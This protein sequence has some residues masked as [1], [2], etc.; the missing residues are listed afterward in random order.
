M[1][2][3]FCF[4]APLCLHSAP[5]PP[6]VQGLILN[7]D[8]NEMSSLSRAVRSGDWLTTS[9]SEGVGPGT[10]SATVEQE[11]P[12]HGNAPFGSSLPRIT[13]EKPQWVTPGPNSYTPQVERGHR[14]AHIDTSGPRLHIE[15]VLSKHFTPG[16][17]AYTEFVPQKPPDQK[18]ISRVNW[19]KKVSPPSIPSND[20]YGYEAAEGGTWVKIPRDLN[21]KRSVVREKKPKG[22]LLDTHGAQHAAFIEPKGR[23][24]EPGP[25]SYDTDVYSAQVEAA[26]PSC[27]FRSIV[28]RVPWAAVP[29][30]PG[31]GYYDAKCAGG[32]APSV[33]SQAF[34]SC[35]NPT[36]ALQRKPRNQAEGT[37][38]TDDSPP[39]PPGVSRPK[40][41]PTL[42][43]AP[44]FPSL[45]SVAPGPGAY[46]VKSGKKGIALKGV[47]GT[48]T[49]RFPSIEHAESEVPGPT[50][51]TPFVIEQNVRRS[52]K[53]NAVFIKPKPKKPPSAA[54]LAVQLR[55]QGVQDVSQDEQAAKPKPREF[56]NVVPNAHKSF[57]GAQRFRTDARKV[58][59]DSQIPG[60]AEYSPCPPQQTKFAYSSNP[61]F[62]KISNK[63]P[64]STTYSMP[65][66]IVKRTFNITL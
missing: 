49:A 24:E 64:T 60:P 4:Y 11:G 35:T 25:G 55:N 57:G 45:R 22:V 46:D 38:H 29:N 33:S 54:A 12:R 52:E 36:A 16:P 14:S 27:A 28:Q 21:P 58:A 63:G 61:R 20:A 19:K 41:P 13:K 32:Y 2:A 15:T 8:I 34:G 3:S 50:D 51:Y 59:D 37:L 66:T 31:P 17:G 53:R 42:S 56:S 48:T 23:A 43:K 10:Y 39:A 5:P 26:E 65:D 1:T 40:Q 9:G 7:A 6:P 18:K 44:R 30:N 62:P 47:F